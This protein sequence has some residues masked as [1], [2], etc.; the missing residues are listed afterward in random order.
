MARGL[1]VLKPLIAFQKLNLCR[2]WM[3]GEQTLNV[4]GKAGKI[5]RRLMIRVA[6]KARGRM[7]RRRETNTLSN[8]AIKR[9][10]WAK[11]NAKVSGLTLNCFAT[12]NPV[13]GGEEFSTDPADLFGEV[14]NWICVW[15]RRRGIRPTAIWTVEN[16]AAGDCPHLHFYFHLPAK[17]FADFQAAFY[18][19]YPGGD[20]I[21]TV[22][23]VR[24]DDGKAIMTDEGKFRSTFWYMCKIMESRAQFARFYRVTRF[25]P[26]PF[27][28]K[29]F[30][31]TANIAVSTA[32]IIAAKAEAAA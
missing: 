15:V 18:A 2:M 9:L 1:I 11:Y 24:R 20:G 12:F 16:S 17:H 8:T 13:R 22:A 6:A 4:I 25:P 27:T 3:G 26:G 14:R 5:E 28:G 29:R 10:D 19:N 23:H 32:D 30:G 21:G 31:M 7:H